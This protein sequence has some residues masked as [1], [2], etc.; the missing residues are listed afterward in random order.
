MPRRGETRPYRPMP[1]DFADA[2][3]RT[4]WEA[5]MDECRAGRVT[6]ARWIEEYDTAAIEAGC[7]QLWELRRQWLEA[8]YALKQPGRKIRGR[9]PGR[10][11]RY[12]LGRTLTPVIP[13]KRG[14]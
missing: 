5:I 11:V 3:A 6:V 4:G 2:F 14:A 12:V 7:P 1:R 8:Q 9:T 10:R 13:P